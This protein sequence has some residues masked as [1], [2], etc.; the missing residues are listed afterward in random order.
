MIVALLGGAGLVIGALVTALVNLLIARSSNKRESMG[1]IVESWEGLLAP[2]RDEV[3]ELRTQVELLRYE[4]FEHRKWRAKAASYIHV[5]IDALRVGGVEV[6][7]VP[8]G[9]DIETQPGGNTNLT[10]VV[11]RNGETGVLMTPS[12]HM[13]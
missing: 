10:P 13:D 2:Y 4:V 9:L 1:L 5:L 6:P 3:K 7:S 12:S 11:L 8:A